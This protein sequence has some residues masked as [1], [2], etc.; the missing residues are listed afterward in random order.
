M[1][2]FKKKLFRKQV[3]LVCGLL[4]STFGI[5]LSKFV[6]EAAS[7]PDHLLEFVAGFQT[8]I[9]AAL[10]GFLLFY[11]AKN[12]M[13][14]RNPEQMKTLYIAETDE[15]RLFIRQ[16]AGSVGMNIVVFG[17]ILG[18]AVAGNINHTVFFTLLGA[19]FF[20][21]I[22]RLFLKIYYRNKY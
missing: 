18:T 9:I 14:L 20:V 13:A 19:G 1:E 10:F 3:W 15:R 17:L 7:A 6:F 22:V 4:L 5:L 2:G 16:Q 8:G 11:I 12:M 21:V